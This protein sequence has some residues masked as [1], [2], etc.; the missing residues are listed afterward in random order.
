M[1]NNTLLLHGIESRV[2]DKARSGATTKRSQYGIETAHTVT[3]RCLLPEIGTKTAKKEKTNFSRL[4]VPK[5]RTHLKH[6]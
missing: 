6:N 3:V 5:R 2:S 4:S 1:S